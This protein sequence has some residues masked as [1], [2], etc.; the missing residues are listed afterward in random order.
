MF[1]IRV[2]L[3]LASSPGSV[4]QLWAPPTRPIIYSTSLQVWPPILDIWVSQLQLWYGVII[5]C[6]VTLRIYLFNL[7]VSFIRYR[8]TMIFI[9]ITRK[10]STPMCNG[11]APSSHVTLRYLE[12]HWSAVA[13][14]RAWAQKFRLKMVIRVISPCSSRPT[15]LIRL[16]FAVPG[17]VDKNE[18]IT[19]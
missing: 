9:S 13:E 4:H 18:Y 7:M 17:A 11:S 6:D 16:V 8:L 3:E 10:A 15:I 5:K 12:N 19:I 2:L 14:R 1:V